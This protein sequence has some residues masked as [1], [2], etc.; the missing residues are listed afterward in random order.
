MSPAACPSPRLRQTGNSL[1]GQRLVRRSVCSS[2]RR[3]HVADRRH[4]RIMLRF[5]HSGY[6]L[7]RP[8]FREHLLL[9]YK[10][11]YR[12]VVQQSR[13][14]FAAQDTA[15]ARCS[16]ICGGGCGGSCDLAQ[17]LPKLTCATGS[18]WLGIVNRGNIA[19]IGIQCRDSGGLRHTI[20]PSFPCSLNRSDLSLQLSR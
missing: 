3:T 5:Q 17:D 6:C 1:A 4:S 7:I 16:Y 12:I 9:H 18:L 2:L 14:D 19:R 15:Q 20:E 11:L 13:V 10:I 8:S